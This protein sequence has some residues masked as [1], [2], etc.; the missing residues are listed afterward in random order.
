M[1][2]FLKKA[3]QMETVIPRLDLHHRVI[4]SFYQFSI[5]IFLIFGWKLTPKAWLKN[6]RINIFNNLTRQS[7]NRYLNQQLNLFSEQAIAISICPM[8]LLYPAMLQA[9]KQYNIDSNLLIEKFDTKKNTE[10]EIIDTCTKYDKLCEFLQIVR[11]M[12]NEEGKMTV[13]D[14][15]F[16]HDVRVNPTQIELEN[17]FV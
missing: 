1:P 10:I 5:M 11:D 3:L 6:Y 8:F 4:Y 7:N 15:I 16:D 12:Q 14:H 17:L 2:I 9:Y 13:F